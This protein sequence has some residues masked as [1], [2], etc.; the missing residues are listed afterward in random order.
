MKIE[1]THPH[2]EILR[3]FRF[4][5]AKTVTGFNPGRHCMA[6][7]LGPRLPKFRPDMPVGSV[8]IASLPGEEIYICGVGEREVGNWNRLEDNFH[9]VIRSAVGLPE[10]SAQTY[11]G[12]TVTVTGGIRVP[13][14]P[15]PAGWRGLPR[16]FTRCRNF[17]YGVQRFGLPT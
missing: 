1:L 12:F 9:L 17:Q 13:I 5:W 6:S 16:S 2:H 8:Q 10:F 7:L 3:G 15:L 11:N 14:A 4:F